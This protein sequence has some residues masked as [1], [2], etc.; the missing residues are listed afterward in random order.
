MALIKRSQLNR[1]RRRRRVAVYIRVS[2]EEQVLHGYSLEAQKE[3]LIEY[4]KQHDLEIVDF[5][6]DE[7]K[8][9]RKELRKRTEVLRML[10][11]IEKGEKGIEMIIFIKIDRWFRNVADYHYVQRILEKH[12]VTWKT[13]QEDYNTET[14]D[15]RMKVN[16]MLSVAE[17]EADR[18]SERIKFV[19]ESKIKKGQVIMG[20]QSLPLGFKVG[21]KDGQKRVIHDPDTAPIILD[22]AEH[23]ETHRSKRLAMLHCNEKYDREYS[24]N[25]YNKLFTNTM[26]Y[27]SFAGN[28]HYC[29][30][31][32]TKERID[33]LK[34]L[35]KRNIRKNPENRVYMFTGLVHCPKCGR[36]MTAQCKRERKN[37]Y[38][39]YRCRRAHNETFCDYTSIV[40]ENRI[41][42]YLLNNIEQL[43][44]DY[45]VSFEITGE[46][47]SNVD[48]VK[49]D[50]K[51]IEDEIERV[52]YRFQKGR[53]SI[54]EY[55]KEYEDLESKLKKLKEETQ[56][57]KPRDN[58][59]LLEFINSDWKL[60]YNTLTPENKRALWQSLIKS[61][62]K[63]GTN[64]FDIE[65]F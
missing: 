60:A 35:V 56:E 27:G 7:G 10:D 40:S 28:D 3:A 13:T 51:K 6:I 41:E 5:Y 14:A 46:A 43:I 1:I 11:D 8:T 54:E 23:F 26:Y 44:N 2:H 36:I 58:S 37:E 17:N 18:T 47:K 59:K 50:I 32:F 65:F 62:V 45:I 61:I 15:G 42:K 53:I 57:K 31:L 21:M 24:Y 29:E 20:D 4:A 33:H 9:A 49:K 39:H 16:I 30:P 48:K 38:K 12:D 19:N 64:S 63:T 34:T 25:R 52:N 55:D 22:Y